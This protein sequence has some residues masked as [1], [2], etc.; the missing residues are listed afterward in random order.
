M[1]VVL[2]SHGVDISS[3]A[4]RSLLAIAEYLS[5]RGAE[6]NVALPG[7]GSL[8]HA[9]DERGIANSSFD[10][11]WA[12]SRNGEDGVASGLGSLSAI[13]AWLSSLDPDVVLTST[14]VIPWFAYPMSRH[15]GYRP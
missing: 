10:Y 6:L 7:D 4:E 5:G 14:S 15:Q 3:G 1:K 8:R 12:A 11:G 9:L 2:A 13:V